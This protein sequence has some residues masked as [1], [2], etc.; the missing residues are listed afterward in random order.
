MI[1]LD[2]PWAYER[3]MQ[4]TSQVAAC[5]VKPPADNSKVLSAFANY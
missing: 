2:S 1:S 5:Q 4:K 3:G